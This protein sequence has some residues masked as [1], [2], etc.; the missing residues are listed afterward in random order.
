MRLKVKTIKKKKKSEI[1]KRFRVFNINF[2][3]PWGVYEAIHGV[4]NAQIS[5]NSRKAKKRFF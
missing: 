1:F 3:D 2:N 4:I 5:P